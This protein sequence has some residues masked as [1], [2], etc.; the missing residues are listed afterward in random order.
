MSYK[1][2]DKVMWRGAWGSDAPKIATIE[3]IELVEEGQKY[4]DDVLEI[5]DDQMQ[6]RTVVVSL[7]AD[8]SWWAYGHQISKL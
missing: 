8:G 4:G 5:E 1:I 6:G 2:G 3:N 7:L